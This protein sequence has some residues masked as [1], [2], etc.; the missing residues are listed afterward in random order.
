[1]NSILRCAAAAAVCTA[2]L[3]AAQAVESGAPITPF[4]VFDFGSGQMPPPSEIG[5]VGLRFASYR[6]HQ[7]RTDD[8]SVSPVKA[9][10]AVD[11]VGVAFIKMTD[12]SLAGAKFGWGAVLPYLKAS[13]DLKIPTPVG[14]LPL[15][16][17]NNA[18]G[19]AQ[20][21][22]L[23]LQWAPSPGLF[24]NFQLTLQAPTGS[25][26]KNRLMNAGTHHWTVAP[27][28]AVSWI[29]ASGLEISTNAQ[30]NFNA[31]NKATDYRSGTEYQQEFA[32][33]QHIGEWTVG[34]GGYHYQQLTDDKGPGVP[35][36]GNRAR[37]TALGPAISYFELGSG[38]PLVWLHAYRE[39][40]AQNRSQGRHFALRAAWTF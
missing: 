32:I 20:L 37:V 40:N 16:G 7:L 9:D 26:D 33:G 8:G 17:R 3:P 19:D 22:P 14:P 5:T 34:L 30:L 36:G 28:V 2:A 15:S 18:Q 6:A 24:T 39:F 23:I 35:P 10:L 29:Q 21:I 31:R 13:L 11:S 4:G 27:S 1:M 38:L 12:I 25:Y